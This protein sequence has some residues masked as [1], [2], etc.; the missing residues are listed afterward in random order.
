MQTI[1]VIFLSEYA[2]YNI[3]KLEF[4]NNS[5]YLD[6]DF[7]GY[8]FTNNDLEIK[9]NVKYD[10][11]DEDEIPHDEYKYKT[12]VKKA[13]E[14]LDA[15]GITEKSV[16]NEFN[17]KILDCMDYEGFLE[18]LNIPIDDWDAKRIERTKKYVTFLKWKNALKK[19]TERLPKTAK[20][21][22]EEL[23]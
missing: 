19:T 21:I 1:G 3:R 11:E 5:S 14:R 16:E 9:S 12:T 22:T 2:I 4:W 20:R 10:D 8:L 15:I 6:F 7:A 13:I 18:H 23:F 17:Q